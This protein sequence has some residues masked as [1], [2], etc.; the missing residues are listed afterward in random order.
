MSGPLGV[1]PHDTA[2][3]NLLIGAL[4]ANTV[5]VLPN[6]ML[7]AM[8]VLVRD[9]LGFGEVVLGVVIATFAAA[10]LL[11]SAPGG[12]L[13]ERIGAART[14]TV[15]AA[16]CG[17]ALVGIAVLARSPL[18]LAACMALGG[19]G[20]GLTQ[21]ATNGVLSGA[22]NPARQGLAFGV[23][24]A[25]IPL[26]GLLSG[27]ALPV[28][29]VQVGWR[30]AFAAGGLLA[31]AVAAVVPRAA[32]EVRAREADGSAGR[33]P[34]DGEQRAPLGPLLVITVSVGLASM[35]ANAV[36]A[37]FVESAVAGGV[38]A[39]AAGLWLTAGGAS[40]IVARTTWGWLADRRTGRHL[41]FV[42]GL[43]GAGAVGLGLLALR[44]DGGVVLT[45]ATA[46]A[47][48]AAWGWPGL[49]NYAIVR[50]SRAAPAAATGVTQSGVFAGVLLG[51]PVF[52][53][54]VETLSY[55][56][57]WSLFAG[58]LVAGAALLLLGR[59]LLVSA[60]RAAEQRAAGPT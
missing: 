43:M 45:V 51:P 2:V 26:A 23:K 35:S 53:A 37:F 15:G 13:S 9:D 20:N 44:P 39:G 38:A 10:A 29:G 31:V 14:M 19:V 58:L 27:L 46:L 36:G 60:R 56:A 1:G 25:S 24:Q 52:G 47:F 41:V 48:G 40:G 54:M 59:R 55:R 6:I 22:V 28:L 49:F 33:G 32:A 42:A 5:V 16:V 12:R 30:W 7:G 3:R 18:T 17:V 34:A 21:P 57:A 8:A 4:L 50:Q 11:T